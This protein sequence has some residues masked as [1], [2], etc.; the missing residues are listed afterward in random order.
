MK[1]VSSVGDAP[2]DCIRVNLERQAPSDQGKASSSSA[3]SSDSSSDG[4]GQSASPSTAGS[5][6]GDSNP[7]DDEEE[8]PESSN[9]RVTPEEPEEVA[10]RLQVP[11]GAKLIRRK[12]IRNLNLMS[13]GHECKFL[14]EAGFSFAM[15][16]EEE[17]FGSF[18]SQELAPPCR[19]LTLKSFIASRCLAC[20]MEREQ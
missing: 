17:H 11:A 4:T 13:G 5:E 18:S 20:K 15:P 16:H 8:E 2:L 14:D 6:N 1:V 7:E 9:Y 19:D 12:Q 3:C 10:A